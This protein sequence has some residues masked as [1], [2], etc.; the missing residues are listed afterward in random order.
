MEIRV[1]WRGALSGFIAGLL[2]FAFARI[3]AE[4]YIQHAIDYES[5]RDDAIAA[6]AKAQGV[7]VQ[8]DG[9]EIF[10]R[11]IQSTA[12]LATGVIAFS[13]AMGALIAVADLVLH[14]RF[15]IR[16]RTL[17]LVLSGLGFL[18][19]YLVPFVK[20]PANPPAIGHTFTIATRAHLYLTMVACSLVFIGVAA[21]LGHRDAVAGVECPGRVGVPGLPG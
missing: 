18:G 10:S 13:T 20:Y 5:G 16:A 11:S 14:G 7:A 9:P 15:N 1:I 2:G 19:V 8:A 3:F 21:F 6:V 12:G 4:S 17:V